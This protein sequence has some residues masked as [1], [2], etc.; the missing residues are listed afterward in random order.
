MLREIVQD[1]VDILLVSETKVDPSFPSSQFAIKGF[2][3]PFRLDRNSSGGGIMLFVREEIPSK[4]LSQ[5]KSNSS[6]ENIFIEIN[7]RSKKWLLSCSYNPNLTLLN[8]HIQNISRSLDF[9][10]SKYDNFIVLWDFNAETSNTT[11]SEF[12]ATYNLKNLIKEPTC[13]KSLK[14]PTCI[15]LILTNRPKCFQN[16]NVFETGLSDFHKLTFTVLKAYFQKQKPKV[17][18]YRS[19][20]KFDNNLFRHDL[21]NELLSKNV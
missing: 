12:C 18:R 3:V 6:V 13:F 7:L 2:S 4:L 5:Y 21:L 9:Y 20:K 10:S 1:K 8:N 11:I 14:N 16:S 19:C 15:D 17:I